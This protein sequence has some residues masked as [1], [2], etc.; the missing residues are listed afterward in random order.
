MANSNNKPTTTPAPNVSSKPFPGPS[1]AP[2]QSG[3]VGG[4]VYEG[5]V[6]RPNPD[7]PTGPK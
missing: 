5:P 7:K 4:N 2:A 1:N 3:A 6:V